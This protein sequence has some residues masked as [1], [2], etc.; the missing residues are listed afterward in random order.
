MIK[1]ST[2]G[3]DETFLQLM[4]LSGSAILKLLGFPPEI[5]D[6]Y[7]F[8]A[9]EFKQK[10]LQKPD[11]EGIP[12]LETLPYRILIEF[13]G[14]RDKFIRYRALANML[15]VCMKSQTDKPII[16][17]IIYTQQQYQDVALPLDRL[18]EGNI[19]LTEK[20]LTDYSEAELLAIDPRLIVL[21]PF[22]VPKDVSKPELQQKAQ[23][24]SRTISEIYP[25]NEQRQEAFNIIGL[26]LLDRFRNL[27][28]QEILDMLNLDLLDT[29]AGQDIFKMGEIEGI[30]KGLAEGEAKGETQTL[31]A[32]REQILAVLE[33]RFTNLPAQTAKNL[34]KIT[35]LPRLMEL[36]YIAYSCTQIEAFLQHCNK[37]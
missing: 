12:I 6:H 35:Q 9:V 36:T 2:R 26:F 27:A 19:K 32:M 31:Q 1:S 24:W 16:G 14:Y 37:D 13:Q 21:A 33:Q 10:Q 25:D 22:T 18:L 11:A 17:I 28:Q 20:V 8:R 34:A 15:Q 4:T 30:A 7:E 29:R 5:A 23:T 3:T